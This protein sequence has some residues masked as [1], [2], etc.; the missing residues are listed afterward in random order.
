MIWARCYAL[1]CLVYGVAA[2]WQTMLDYWHNLL[3]V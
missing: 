3:A 2:I 1:L